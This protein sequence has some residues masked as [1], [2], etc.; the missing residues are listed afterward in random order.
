V[1]ERWTGAAVWSLYQIAAVRARMLQ[2]AHHDS[3][4]RVPAVAFEVEL[5]LEGLID[6][7][8]GLAQGLEQVRAGAFVFALAGRAQQP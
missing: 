3:G 2:D 4:G 8:D 1:S 5:A 7:F 6:R